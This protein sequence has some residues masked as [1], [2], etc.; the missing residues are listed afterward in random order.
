MSKKVEL[1]TAAERP[2]NDSADDTP[3]YTAY[4]GGQKYRVDH[5]KYG[6]FYCYAPS[7]VAA[8]IMAADHWGEVWH[9][10]YFYDRCKPERV[11]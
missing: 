8:I 2:G 3:R 1:A 4:L 5:P 10:E 11:L 7:C 6:T 9:S